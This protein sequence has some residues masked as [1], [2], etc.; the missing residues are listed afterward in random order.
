MA[1]A[2]QDL[3]VERMV[4]G[5]VAVARLGTGEVALVVGALPGELVRVALERSKGVMRGRVEEVLE[6]SPHRIDPPE[7]P[8]LDYGH[9]SY[10][11]QL[12]LK[13]E[14]V[15]DALRR[16]F[17]GAVPGSLAPVPAVLP[18]PSIWRYR[19]V[20]Q[21]AVVWR[22]GG[23]AL[24]YR[25]Q[26]TAEVVPLD[27]DPVAT[28]G[29]DA[30]YRAAREVL[31]RAASAGRRPRVL[32]L[33]IRANDEGEALVALVGQGEAARSLDL[34]HRLVEAGVAGVMW[35]PA[36]PRGR[37]RRGTERLAGR[38]TVLQRFNDLSLS[39]SA[40]S[41][42]QPNAAG[43]ARLY[44]ELARWAGSGGQ[45]LELYAGGGAIAFHLAER[46]ETV[47]ALE[48]DSSAVARGRADAERLG[49]GNVRFVR[50]DARRLAPPSGVDLVV[51]DPPRTG[52]SAELRAALVAGSFPRLAYVSCDAA[53]W[54]RDVADLHGKGLRLTRAQP[55][56]LY[57]HTHHVEVLSL[58][59]RA[60]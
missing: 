25:R 16:A 18:S 55:F 3:R 1:T 15:E 37:F 35:A 23:A 38:R 44:R 51:V 60:A 6:P 19:N 36:D 43:A 2:V 17:G 31:S 41:F 33:V 30:S 11:H 48:V 39:V 54:A 57:P 45:A 40:T 20:V 34:G 58:L 12:E 47:T 28:P 7:H 29:V 13:R 59:E 56:D 52:L 21:P 4:H 26:G 22:A 27:S 46:F 9:V 14:V 32:E 49:L 42:S 10:D 24:G 53:T 50:G 5:G 8:G